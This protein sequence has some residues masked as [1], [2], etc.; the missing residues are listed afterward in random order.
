ME[1]IP[2][3]RKARGDGMRAFLRKDKLEIDKELF[4]LADMEEGKN[5][6]RWTP[7]NLGKD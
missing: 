7:K 3:L 5:L 1:L 6:V 4:V 2:W